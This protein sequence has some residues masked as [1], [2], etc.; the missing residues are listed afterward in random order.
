MPSCTESRRASQKAST[1]NTILRP[2]VKGLIIATL[3]VSKNWLTNP[4]LT[5]F[6][7]WPQKIENGSQFSQS[8]LYFRLQYE[9]PWTQ[10][11]QL[12]LYL[13]KLSYIRKESSVLLLLLLLVLCM[14]RLGDSPGFW[15]G[16]G[17]R[18]AVT[19]EPMHSVEVGVLISIF[20]REPAREN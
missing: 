11:V 6:R 8:K 1:C 13:D 15:S 4:V 2:L 16:M 3:Y 17:W 9:T 12:N 10:E 14:S 20:E 18:L 5:Y 19:F 7:V